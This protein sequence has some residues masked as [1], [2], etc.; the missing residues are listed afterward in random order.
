MLRSFRLERWADVG[1]RLGVV[2]TGPALACLLLGA[3]H[4]ASA[5]V[6]CSKST[7]KGESFKLASSCSGKWTQ[8]A[9]ETF[10]GPQGPQG[11]QGSQGLQGPSGVV[12][13]DYASGGVGS[14]HPSAQL[15]FLAPPATVF[16]NSGEHVLVNSQRSFGTTFGGA[17]N[18]DLAICYRRN[19]ESGLNPVGVILSDHALTAAQRVPMG[20]SGVI[21]DLSTGS[22]DVGLCG[23]DDGNGGWVNNG[24][25]STTALVF[26]AP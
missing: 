16:V 25:G 19:G 22:Y 18:L 13:F 11:E 17:A 2:L 9:E 24:P 15:Q 8:L 23:D 20:L 1:A 14:N 12:A 5:V 21:S 6:V 4:P 26:R 10:R 3:A 7:K